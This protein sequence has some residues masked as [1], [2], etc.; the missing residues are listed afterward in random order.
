[1]SME[2]AR[3]RYLRSD[4]TVGCANVS[5]AISGTAHCLAQ[6]KHAK[7]TTLYIE[8]YNSGPILTTSTLLT[9]F[10]A[11]FVAFGGAFAEEL[12]AMKA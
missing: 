2:H 6:Q 12:M 3:R 7:K 11:I 1:M 10:T 5:S 4:R 9:F 8:K